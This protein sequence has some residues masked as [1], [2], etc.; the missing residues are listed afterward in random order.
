MPQPP[1]PATLPE[2]DPYSYS[3]SR[4]TRDPIQCPHVACRAKIPL[5]RFDYLERHWNVRHP[6]DP[7]PTLTCPLCQA[8]GLSHNAMRRH[9][10]TCGVP[11]PPT[12]TNIAL[13]NL[14][15]HPEETIEHM[16][17]EC[18]DP[19]LRRA[20][21]KWR[22]TLRPR[23]NSGM[24]EVLHNPQVLEFVAESPSSPRL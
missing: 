5:A 20:W 19:E 23:H 6:N 22:P 2:P 15:A 4:G 16:V 13:F 3:E 11:I 18:D 17:M 1:S 14:P 10:K 24:D 12:P 21:A 8:T 9:R 7:F